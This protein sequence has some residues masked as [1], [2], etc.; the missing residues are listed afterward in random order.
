M[1]GEEC[2]LLSPLLTLASLLADRPPAVGSGNMHY[3]LGEERKRP[4]SW[5]RLREVMEGW[6]KE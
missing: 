6:L 2:T 3:H 1:S 5:G 4:K